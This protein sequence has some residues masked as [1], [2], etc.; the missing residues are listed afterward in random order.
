MIE[1]N[2]LKEIAN[3]AR[4]LDPGHIE[5]AREGITIKNYGAGETVSALGL[6][7]DSW[8][9]VIRGLMKMRILSPDG[10]EVSLAGLHAGGWFGEG[11]VLKGED[12]RY[13]ILALRDTTL[14]VMN[15]QTFLWLFENSLVFNQFLA[16]QL[17][18][19]LG[20]FIGLVIHDRMLSTTARVAR[21]ISTLFDPILYP[22]AG[23]TLEITQEEIG[24]IAGLTRPVT[25][26]ALRTLEQKGLI[27][28]E[29][30][31]IIALDLAALADLN[32]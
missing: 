2:K 1:A 17:N 27:R 4:E 26:Q 28:L 12:R 9:G 10:R 3:W 22:D 32:V 6:P 24:L 29:Y 18:Q 14:A 25:N 5:R 23:D 8:I 16:R 30:G 21:T 19:R 13:E 11:S 7:S 31:K 20:Q 15:R